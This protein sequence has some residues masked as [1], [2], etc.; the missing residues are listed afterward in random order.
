MPIAGLIALTGLVS[1]L[2]WPTPLTHADQALFRLGADVIRRGGLLYADFWDI[3]QPGIYWFYAAAEACLGAGYTAAGVHKLSSIWLML[4]AL[5]AGRAL[6]DAIGDRQRVWWIAPG[7][8]AA[9]QVAATNVISISQVEWLLPLPAL[10]LTALAVRAIRNARWTVPGAVAA[11]VLTGVIAWLKLV[12]APVPAAILLCSALC[13]GSSG[14]SARVGV[15]HRARNLAHLTAWSVLGF[16]LLS[17]VVALPFLLRGQFDLFLWTNFTYPMQA[18]SQVEAAPASRLMSSTLK[19]LFTCGPLLPIAAFGAWS[20]LRHGDSTRRF[21]A[22]AMLA[23]LFVQAMMLL[24]QRYSWWFHHFAA[25]VWPVGI[26][27]ALAFA[28]APVTSRMRRTLTALLAIATL[29]CAT[30]LGYN[31]RHASR[32]AEEPL[33]Y[34]NQLPELAAAIAQST[35]RNAIVFGSPLLHQATGLRPISSTTGFLAPF[36]PES[37]WQTLRGLATAQPPDFIYIGPH[38]TAVVERRGSWV[39]PMLVNAYRPLAQDADGGRWWLRVA[40]VSSCS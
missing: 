9:A 8:I 29:T 30:S 28:Q 5:S 10:A 40:P 19:W 35:C 12:L 7:L 11:G 22:L 23:W 13:I 36:M 31:L 1:L 25:F 3:K 27:V 21:L 2:L 14:A 18:L 17:F 32:H 34:S 39:A 16:L 38:F 20:S 26:L 37:A 6:H 4:T 24:V 15:R 33:A